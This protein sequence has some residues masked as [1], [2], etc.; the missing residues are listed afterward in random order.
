[1]SVSAAGPAT[2][3]RVRELRKRYGAVEAVRGIDLDVRAGEIFGLIG[4]DGAG[5]T[6]TFQILGGVMPQTSAPP[7]CSAGRR[8]TRAPL[9]AT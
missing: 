1:M 2:A 4:P 5:K 8:E 6:S 9:S 7:S 3:I